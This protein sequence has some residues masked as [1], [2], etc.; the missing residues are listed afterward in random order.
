MG[1]GFDDDCVWDDALLSWTGDTEGGGANC[2]G[3]AFCAW[4]GGGGGK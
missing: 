1:K 4:A 3:G 2:G